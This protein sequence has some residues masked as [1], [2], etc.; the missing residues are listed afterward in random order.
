MNLLFNII[1][2]FVV[3]FILLVIGFM[4][5]RFFYFFRNPARVI[6][7]NDNNILSPAD[8][9]IVYIKKVCNG[10]DTPIF[11]IKERTVIKL[12]ELIETNSEE[13][14]DKEGYLIG[15]FMSPFDVH[16]NRMPI[17]GHIKKI[18]HYFPNSPLSK[19]INQGMYNIFSNLLFDEKPYYHDA[20]FIID[21]ERASYIIKNNQCTVYVTQIADRW[22]NKIVNF[23]DEKILSQG[24]IFGMIR[25]GSQVDIFVPS[26]DTYRIKV[27]LGEKVKA[28]ISV[29]MTKE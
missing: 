2:L 15:I 24:E 14:K 13:L 17:K 29:L 10:K 12:Y 7:C 23:V 3:I 27:S 19:K 26:L 21:N 9:Q 11:S 20:D 6:S 8:G 28:G 18:G 16:Y 5:W 22:V 4:F 25:M 1:I